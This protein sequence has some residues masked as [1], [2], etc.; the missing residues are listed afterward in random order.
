MTLTAENQRKAKISDNGNGYA[1]FIQKS[2]YI[3][4]DGLYARSTDLSGASNGRPFTVK[5]SKHIAII[6]SVGLNPNRFVNAH[7][8]DILNS[9]D[10]LL[11]DNEAYVYH[12]HCITA[13]QS[14]RVVVRRQYCNPREGSIPG[15]VGSHQ[16]LGKGDALLSMYPC[17]ECILENSIAEATRNK[18]Y[19]LE[20]NSTFGKSVLM[21][22]SQ[23]LG[24]ICFKCGYGNGAYLNS[25]KVPDINHTPRNIV[26]KNIAFVDFNSPSS[27][28]RASDGVNISIEHVTV[29][30]AGGGTGI[31]ADDGVNGATPVQQSIIIRDTTV[32]GL[33]GIG[34]NK[35]S[36]AYNTWSGDNVNS[37]NNRTNFIPSLPAHW[38]TATTT[39]PQLGTCKVWIPASS[40]LKGAGTG[41][42]DIGA[43]ILYRYVNG[44]LTTTPLW[45]PRTGEF[46]HGASDLDGINRVA[47]ES[48]FDIHKRLNINTRDCPFPRDY[49][50][51]DSDTKVPASPVGLKV[52]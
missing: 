40:P 6:N 51:G 43:N 38:G 15:G 3:I 8:W 30:G 11:E 23:V 13:W 49:G 50:N 36:S 45:D 52:S 21:S 1:I 31:T 41:G 47:G 27:A 48:L 29:I 7:V 5:L 9:E 39:N 44:V 26:L 4:A 22:G 33:T 12:R 34:F 19:L 24:S 46:P 25:R 28:I 2:A 17:Q 16:G 32:Q 37:Y 18:T 42:S 20:M 10:I 35:S 14:K